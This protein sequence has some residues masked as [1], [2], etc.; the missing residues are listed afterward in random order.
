MIY[1]TPS[2]DTFN[3]YISSSMYCAFC[4]ATSERW[5][6]MSRMAAVVA[7]RL[8]LVNVTCICVTAILA[9]ACLDSALATAL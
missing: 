1:T 8:L 5:C 4:L 3:V 7:R 9:A 2:C 6:R